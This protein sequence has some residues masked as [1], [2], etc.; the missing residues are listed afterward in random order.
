M[1][2]PKIAIAKARCA[3]LSFVDYQN[4]QQPLIERKR[5]LKDG[6]VQIFHTRKKVVS[7]T[8][9]DTG[10]QLIWDYMKAY[11][12]A[13]QWGFTPENG[14]EL[15]TL[16]TNSPKLAKE[17]KASDR[18]M[19]NHLRKLKSLGLITRYTFHGT[20]HDFELCI[21]PKIMFATDPKQVKDLLQEQKFGLPS[22][23]ESTDFPLNVSFATTGNLEREISNVDKCG[24]SAPPAAMPNGDGAGNTAGKSVAGNTEPHHGQIPAKNRPAEGLL[25]T[26]LEKETGGAAAPE[27]VAV[28]PKYRLFVLEFWQ[29]AK[30]IIY[31]HLEF[32]PLQE[33]MA[34]YAIWSGVYLNF[35]S[36]PTEQEWDQYHQEAL[37]RLRLASN[38]YRNHPNKYPPMPYSEFKDGCGYFDQENAYGFQK[39]QDWLEKKIVWAHQNKVADALRRA[40]LDFQDYYR[41]KATKRLQEKSP[42]QLFKFHEAKIR[43]LGPAALSQ[44][45]QL[46]TVPT[47][48]I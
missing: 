42:L 12:Q 48:P 31:P 10:L 17:C 44:F 20:F 27:K 1:L 33:R 41:G 14:N 26:S 36:G 21:N 7:R 35:R 38:Y 22:L 16:F 3:W 34:I 29:Y 18:T 8:V 11:E 23:P 9:K 13:I 24:A 25:A 39:T 46:F 6:T 28:N 4:N 43:R 45:H 47:N 15:P 30:A 40:K 2:I 5:V 19:R 37:E 32:D